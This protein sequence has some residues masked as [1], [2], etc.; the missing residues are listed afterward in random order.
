MY[1]YLEENTNSYHKGQLTPFFIAALAILIIAIMVTVNIG[2]VAQI[3]T[4]TSNS[5]DAGALAAVSAMATTF[6]AL[7]A[8]ASYMYAKYI[9]YKLII[10]SLL[11]EVVEATIIMETSILAAWVLGLVAVANACTPYT[12]YWVYLASIAGAIILLFNA[13]Y[14]LTVQQNLMGSVKS[15]IKTL[16]DFEEEMYLDIRDFVDES[17]IS[18]RET[19]LSLSFSNS[20]ISSMLTDTQQDDYDTFIDGLT[21]SSAT[22]SWT[23]GQNRDHS[24]TASVDLKDVDRYLLLETKEDEDTIVNIYFTAYYLMAA[25]SALWLGYVTLGYIKL[26]MAAYGYGKCPSWHLPIPYFGCILPWACFLGIAKTIPYNTKTGWLGAY[27]AGFYPIFYLIE[28]GVQENGTYWEPTRDVGSKIIPTIVDVDHSRCVNTSSTQDHEGSD[29]GNKIFTL[30]ETA[31]PLSSSKAD[32]SFSGGSIDGR[33][34][35]G[36]GHIPRLVDSCTP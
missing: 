14:W 10:E 31:Y 4:K 21:G 36:V 22:H 16:Q 11:D 34:T 9:E 35:T 23:D 24:V 33:G 20:G 26:L 30:W 15:I 7:G 13:S 32:A 6:N 5:A 8:Y 3:K 28:R 25:V 18:A 2:K 12:G 27:V 1:L 29:K 19:S 17:I